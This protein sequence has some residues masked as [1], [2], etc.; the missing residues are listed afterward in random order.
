MRD[1]TVRL[2]ALDPEAGAALRVIAYF[3]DLVAH[4]AGLPAIVRGAAILAACP[5]ALVDPAQHVRVRI[6]AGGVAGTPGPREA[7]WPW[8]PVGSGGGELWLERDDEPHQIDAMV[9]ERAAAAIGSV[10]QRS[11]GR[12]SRGRD[13]A[14]TRI[15]LDPASSAPDR[16]AAAQRLHLSPTSRVRAVA[17]TDGMR[18]EPGDQPPSVVGRVGVGPIGSPDELPGSGTAARL[19]LRLTADGTPA[20]PGPT[21]VHAQDVGG[22]LVLASAV[23]PDTSKHAD[24]VGLEHLAG[25]HPWL[26]ATLA[27]MAEQSS[28]RGAAAALHVHHSTLQ[29]RI[30]HAERMLGWSISDPAGRFRLQIALVLRRLHRTASDPHPADD[31][32]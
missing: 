19:A 27:A 32:Y 28:L 22:L 16:A 7:G 20:D 30:V 10:R 23:G 25:E 18:I 17:S 29:E 13:D 24:V 12:P 5:A 26:L 1:L 9:L 14:D 31:G 2:D 4:G 21:I 11:P 6:G 8:T 15:L 3:D